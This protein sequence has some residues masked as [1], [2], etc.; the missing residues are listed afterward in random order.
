MKSLINPVDEA[1]QSETS[2]CLHEDKVDESRIDTQGGQHR[3]CVSFELTVQVAVF[4]INDN[5]D[6]SK[7]E[8][9]AIWFDQGEMRIFKAECVATVQMILE[10]KPL[11]SC[12]HCA[13][14][15]EYRIPGGL[16]SR[17]QN[18]YNAFK[19]VLETQDSQW[20]MNED[21]PEAISA[22]YLK[23]SAS[24]LQAAQ[25]LA[26]CDQEQVYPSPKRAPT[27]Q[28][29]IDI[30]QNVKKID[31]TRRSSSSTTLMTSAAA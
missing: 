5:N 2:R 6:V 30:L 31:E 15:L 10:E 18:K 24:C 29:D 14:G 9:D 26:R 13:R 25:R 27:A 1:T 28:I 21:D 16:K 23:V 22:A 3:R 7:E 8:I 20:E 11:D 4:H 12:T 19:A 17:R